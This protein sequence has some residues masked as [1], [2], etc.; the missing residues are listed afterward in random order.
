M[1]EMRH[2]RKSFYGVKVLD[3]VSIN[4]YPGET[5]ALLGEN[6]AGKSTLIKILNGD[7]SRDAG[8]VILDRVPVHFAEPRDAEGA[9]I[10]MI[11]QELHYAPELSVAEN[12]LLGR[13]PHRQ[14][15][16][17]WMID[18]NAAREQAREALKLLNVNI[19]PM[20]KM[21]DLSVVEREIIEIVKAI[22][23]KARI[24]VMDEPTAALTPPEVQQLFG[25]IRDLCKQGIGIIYISHRLD[26][27]FQ[28]AQRVTVLRDGKHVD[29]R[30]IAEMTHKALVH[31]MVGRDIEERAEV[32]KGTAVRFVKALLLSSSVIDFWKCRG[33][34][35]PAHLRISAFRCA[36]AR[37]SLCLAYLVR[38]I[39]PLP[40]RSLVLK[41]RTVGLSTSVDIPCR[42]PRRRMPSVQASALSRS[43]AR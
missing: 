3:D 38:D 28:I 16:F 37:S 26:E 23:R 27:V 8:D 5:L 13:L 9:G 2:I 14:G 6:G 19:D 43:T 18:W 32:R 36:L 12:L 7:Y 31:M 42:L 24:I 15:V 35:K 29:T 30:P 1:L 11:Y 39:T 41:K 40:R 25:I 34:P 21:R 10:R 33:W 4:L 20:T 22:S 17:G